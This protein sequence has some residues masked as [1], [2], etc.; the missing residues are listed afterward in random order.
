MRRRQIAAAKA[1]A[2]IEAAKPEAQR[3]ESSETV[4]D[5]PDITCLECGQVCKSNAGLAAH[6]RFA[7]KHVDTRRSDKPDNN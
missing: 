3:S 6:M 2:N 4:M 5:K 7:H 1:A